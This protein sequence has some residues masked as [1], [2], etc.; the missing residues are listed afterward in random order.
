MNAARN[1]NKQDSIGSSNFSEIVSCSNCIYKKSSQCHEILEQSIEKVKFFQ[2][3]DLI[4]IEYLKLLGES[5]L[6]LNLV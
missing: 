6:N 3:I 2:E 1:W 4:S 5:G